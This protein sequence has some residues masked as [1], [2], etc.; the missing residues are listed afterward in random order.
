[1]SAEF[2]KGIAKLRDQLIVVLD[3]ERV[4]AST[5]RIALEQFIQAMNS[6]ELA[7]RG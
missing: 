6:Q 5:D 2:V 3:V 1:V 7:V 4:L